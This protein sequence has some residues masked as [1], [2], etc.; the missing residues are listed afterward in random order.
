MVAS[1]AAQLQDKRR[2]Q[3]LAAAEAEAGRVKLAEMDVKIVEAEEQLCVLKQQREKKAE[4][5]AG[6][7][8]VEAACATSAEEE[9][10]KLGGYPELL[11][12]LEQEDDKK[13]EARVEGGGQT[14]TKR[15]RVEADAGKVVVA[16]R[17]R[18]SGMA[19]D[20]EALMREGLEWFCGG[21]FQVVDEVRGQMLVEAA[22]AGRRC[23]AG[24]NQTPNL[25]SLCRALIQRG[26]GC[27]GTRVVN[28]AR[29]HEVDKRW[30]SGAGTVAMPGATRQWSSYYYYRGPGPTFP[31]GLLSV[32]SGR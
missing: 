14:R 16:K 2:D 5:V 10:N 29:V 22:A 4:K 23:L 9:E 18:S 3:G 7:E 24:Q 8:Q 15:I 32:D 31:L 28:S 11:A 17:Q 21:N 13:G 1:L 20:F 30:P 12:L 25:W 26:R 19:V 27:E 6:L